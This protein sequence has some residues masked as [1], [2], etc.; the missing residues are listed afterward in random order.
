MAKLHD[1]ISGTFTSINHAHAF[2]ALRSYIKTGRQQAQN[3][4]DT[5]YQ[6]HATGAWQPQPG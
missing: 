4:L 3:T 6:L 1:K 5:L 2:C